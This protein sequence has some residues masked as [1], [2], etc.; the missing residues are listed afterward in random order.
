MHL[1]GMI[2][3]RSAR[4][5]SERELGCMLGKYMIWPLPVSLIPSPLF[6]SLTLYDPAPLDLFLF[7]P[8]AFVLSISSAWTILSWILARLP[9]LFIQILGQMSTATSTLCPKILSCLPMTFNSIG[10]ILN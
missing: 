7:L 2:G 1:E 8:Q 5:L 3:Q 6:L 4:R 10:N 9:L